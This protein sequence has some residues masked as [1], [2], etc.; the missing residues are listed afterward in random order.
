MRSNPVKITVLLFILLGTLFNA[1]TV[2]AG[3]AGK[4]F[5]FI[6]FGDTRPC[7]I[8]EGC[9]LSGEIPRVLAQRYNAS[10]I[11]FTYKVNPNKSIDNCLETVTVN[12][13]NKKPE[14]LYFNLRAI[15]HKVEK[16]GVPIFSFKGWKTVAD[17]ISS[18]FLQAPAKQP[19]FAIHG[20]DMVL[21]GSRGKM[22]SPYW[23]LFHSYY[24][25][26]LLPSPDTGKHRFFP[27]VGNHEMWYDTEMTGFRHYFPWLKE[28]GFTNENRIY[29]FIH[30]NCL[31]IFLD[32]GDYA[33][34]GTAWT[35]TAPPFEKQM[36]FLE[37]Q[38]KN[39]PK[40]VKH[41]FVTYHKPSFVQVGHDPLPKDQNP[42][43]AVL[44]KYA[45][46]FNIMV[47]NSHVHSTEY[48][49]VDG[50]QYLVVGA[51]GAPQA[52]KP[53]E[54]PSTEKELYWNG[55]PRKFELNY[56]KVHVKGKKVS[57]DVIRFHPPEFKKEP[58]ETIIK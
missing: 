54:K 48:Y 33:P 38:I 41:I 36:T 58:P 31:F 28:Y 55:K 14:V 35:S 19:D 26:L 2:L 30:K 17:S 34:G 18:E 40:S 4:S 15:P 25:T 1:S 53:C 10:G 7:V 11:T 24:G 56:M 45:D 37:N 8:L 43:D 44:K 21:N 32:C 6:V 27:A 39:A 42:H 47:F 29:H 9:D 20:G 5:D 50:I 12:E 57:V 22:Y 3:N 46:K 23:M 49:K 51:G 13:P 16:G 52:F